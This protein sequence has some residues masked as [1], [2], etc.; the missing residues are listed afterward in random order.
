[1]SKPLSSAGLLLSDLHL[2]EVVSP[3]QMDGLNWVD[4]NVL[5]DRFRFTYRNALHL[6]SDHAGSNR[7]EELH[8]CFGGD[9]V[10]GVRHLEHVET[11]DLTPMEQ[12]DAIVDLLCDGVGEIYVW[13]N[14]RGIRLK[15]H[16]VAGNHGDL[17]D[18]P[19]K[20]HY[21]QNLDWAAYWAA[22]KRIAPL[23]P[24]VEWDI[25]DALWTEFE[26]AGRLYRL[27]HGHLPGK[28]K[29]FTA[30]GDGPLGPA[31]PGLRLDVRMRRQARSVPGRRPYDTLLKCHDH[32][33]FAS[34]DMIQNGSIIG[35]GEYAMTRGFPYQAPMQALWIGHPIWGIT[36]QMKIHC[37]PEGSTI[38]GE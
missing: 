33:Y 5:E 17:G 4:K 30:R 2:G 31:G 9:M 16:C 19:A 36:H 24:D 35:Y 10:S 13:C 34:D 7:L 1:M 8:L 14:G 29:P 22:Q 27:M 12:L 11:N 37:T 28:G 6:L 20:N 25:P 32:W 26:M 18:H 3:A 38:I 21:G 23:A 15:I